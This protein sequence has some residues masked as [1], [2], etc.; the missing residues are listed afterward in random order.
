[1]GE[2]ENQAEF[3]YEKLKVSINPGQVLLEFFREMTSLEAGRPEII[4]INRLIKMFGRFTVYFGIMD[5]SKY[6]SDQLIGNLYPLLYTICKSR[7]EK[8]HKESFSPAQESLDKLL[9]ELDKEREKARKSKG[10]VPS[11][12][13]LR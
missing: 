1:M 12:E 5:L 7:F 2:M 4:M 3:Y 11:P 9:K 13:G 6:R 8:I 10:K